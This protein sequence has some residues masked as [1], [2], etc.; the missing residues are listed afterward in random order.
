MLRM[1][2]TVSI[3]RHWD[4]ET[5]NFLSYDLFTVSNVKSLN[6]LFRSPLGPK[7]SLDF[8]ATSSIELECFSSAAVYQF[9][10][11]LYTESCF[12]L[13]EGKSVLLF[14]VLFLVQDNCF[15]IGSHVL[16]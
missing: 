11:G 13:A 1:I 2:C 8:I 14:P 6:L 7:M 5:K 3:T 4:I 10:S 9:H 16:T 12:V 15:Y